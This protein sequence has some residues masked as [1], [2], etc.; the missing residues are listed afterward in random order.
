MNIKPSV[1]NGD[2][3]NLE[4]CFQYLA[5]Q[6]D[7][8][9]TSNMVIMEVSLPTGFKAEIDFNKNLE[10]D[11][12]V[13]RIETKNDETIMLLYFDKLLS[14]KGHCVNIET[15]KTTEVEERQPAAVVMYDYYDISR[16]NTEFYTV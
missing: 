8:S 6:Q 10:E 4:V 16:F 2:E 13:Q 14:G 7:L 3:M 15:F 9:N 5:H 12:F 1:N 11:E